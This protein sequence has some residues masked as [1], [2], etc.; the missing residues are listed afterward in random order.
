MTEVDLALVRRL[1]VIIGE[2]LDR[3]G[4]AASS[5]SQ[6]L[7]F[8]AMAAEVAREYS[9]GERMAAGLQPLEPAEEKRLVKAICARMYG[10]GPLQRL[11]DDS[12]IEDI[13]LNGWQ[14]VFVVRADGTRDRED[15][16][17]DSDDE[18]IELVQHVAMYAGINSRHFDAAN[19]QLD[20]RLPDGSR[21]SATMG[22]CAQPVVSIRRD[23]LEDL[24]IEDLVELKTFSPQA[25]D[26]YRAL[27]ESRCNVMI[28]GATGSG[29]T[30]TLRAGAGA[31]DPWER[32]ITVE[33]AL[34][35]GLGRYEERHPNIVE[36]E[37]RMANSEGAGA[38]PMSELVRRSLRMGPDR[39]I[40]GEVLGPE[41]LT[42]L[43]AMTQGNDGS[44]STIHARNA[45]E[46]FNR[47]TTYA[48]QAEE[49]MPKEATGSLIAG[50]LDF[51][52]FLSRDRRTHQRR[53]TTILE[54][55]GATGDQ[56]AT[57]EIFTFD[58]AAGQ[59]VWNPGVT[60]VVREEQ[61]REAGW[62]PPAQGWAWS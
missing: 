52:L 35:L 62:E 15:P 8:E 38:V 49:R 31:I 34:E 19:P 13:H 44:L 4:H 11:L 23:R 16:I 54:I 32:I 46:V 7:R 48:L 45:R 47:I 51:V 43:N 41:I 9:V 26:F 14:R 53:L 36:F 59:A 57:S 42:M 50:G 3:E 33:K 2:R 58:P 6:R 10:A 29:K 1:H 40:V 28:A 12:T 27:V 37:E 30:T 20:L 56:V 5:I 17:V 60:H 25:A 21:L 22:V 55:T 24:S 18:L 39:V 61:L